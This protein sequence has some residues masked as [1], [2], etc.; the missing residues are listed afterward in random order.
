MKDLP[1]KLREK[2]AELR[3]AAETDK[4]IKT[5]QVVTAITGIEALKRKLQTR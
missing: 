2:A 1:E 4:V 5:A 3:K